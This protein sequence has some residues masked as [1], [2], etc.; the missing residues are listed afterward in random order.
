[1]TLP[2]SSRHP[3]SS[4]QIVRFALPALLLAGCGLSGPAH[5]PTSPYVADIK[6]GLASFDPV[7]IH[8]KP[9]ETV[10]FR[11]TAIVVHTVTDDLNLAGNVK[12]AAAPA[13]AA[14]FNSGD[15]PPGEIYTRTF[16]QPGIYR[17]FC[18]HHESDGMVARIIVDPA[19]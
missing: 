15:I 13:G 8:I 5:G 14:P 3:A 18:T 2:L 16:T 12:D 6:M 17:Y 1:M 4:L 10:D 11:N 9:G 19:S 7:V